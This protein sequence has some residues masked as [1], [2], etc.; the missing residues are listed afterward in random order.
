MKFINFKPLEILNLRRIRISLC[1]G[2]RIV[3]HI[4]LVVLHLEQNE[5]LY[6]INDCGRIKVNLLL[7]TLVKL[8]K[9]RGKSIKSSILI[10]NS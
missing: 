1:T 9:S 5:L 7:F 2:G 8:S 3:K 10:S 6:T 4:F